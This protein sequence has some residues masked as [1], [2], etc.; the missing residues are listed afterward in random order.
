VEKWSVKVKFDHIQIF[1]NLS[2]T[3]VLPAGG[4]LNPKY[5]LVV[6]YYN[7]RELFVK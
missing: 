6:T 5:I 2:A 7:A 1:L 3:E 4:L